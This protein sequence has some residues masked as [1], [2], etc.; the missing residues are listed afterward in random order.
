ML[1]AF[2]ER[3][4]AITGQGDDL[5]FL[6]LDEIVSVLRGDTAPLASVPARRQ[7]F[8]TLRALPAYPTF[9][10]GA[11]DPV[12]WAA[13]VESPASE[14]ARRWPVCGSAAVGGQVEGVARVITD[15]EDADA[16]EPGDILV[17]EVTNVGWTPL[18]THISGVVTDVGAPLSH[19]VIV[20]R[21]LGIPA[22]VGCLDATRRIRSG[23][24][25][26]IDGERAV[27][28]PI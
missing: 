21:E 22:V 12:G 19:A 13:G 7:E 8:D 6:T 9:I 4:G 16:L 20:A 27:V 26:R 10:R 23:D 25:I 15:L 11:F 14:E 5:Y 17:T 28:E 2:V 24:R 1:R 3:A 18:F